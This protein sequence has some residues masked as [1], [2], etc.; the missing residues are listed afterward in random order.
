MA[1]LK[2]KQTEKGLE[3]LKKS[4]AKETGPGFLNQVAYSLADMNVGLDMA[5]EYGE[6]SLHLAEANTIKAESEDYGYVA[7]LMLGTIWDTVGWIYFRQGEYEK[8]LPYV[9]A[10]WLLLQKDDIGNHLAQIYVKLG[11]K[12]EAAHTYRLAYSLAD[13]NYSSTASADVKKQILQRYKDLAGKDA[14]PAVISISRR[15]DGT[16]TPLPTEELSRMRSFK[17]SSTV[18]DRGS[19]VFSIVFSPS[20]VEE[21]KYVSGSE[22]L[23]G[24]E[25][26]IAA[27]KFGVEFPDVG[28]VRLY[29]RGMAVCE[30][31]EGCNVVLLLPDSV[32]AVDQAATPN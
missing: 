23:K 26:Q 28:P 18:R 6:K 8:A 14:N 25:K 9:R 5:Q 12:Q 16:F 2:N 32:H 11:K 4:L 20:K 24:M 21:V 29:R 30:K 27:M 7:S 3:L 17:L 13:H 19:A 31:V 1:Y 10:A 15:S 22:S